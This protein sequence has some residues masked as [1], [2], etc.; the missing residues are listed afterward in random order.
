MALRV[1]GLWCFGFFC[2][3]F[4]WVC[5]SLCV[6]IDKFWFLIPF[7]AIGLP[8][9]L[10]LIHIGILASVLS[11]FRIS[12]PF[13]SLFYCAFLLSWCLAEWFRGCLIFGGFPWNFL[14]HFWGN[15]LF[16]MQSAALLGSY[17]L[18]AFTLC[19]LSIPYF[20]LGRDFSFKQRSLLTGSLALLVVCLSFWG[21][22]RI[23][24]PVT[25][26]AKPWLRIVQ[27]NISQIDKMNPD[28][29]PDILNTLKTLTQKP[30]AK[31]LTA[32]ISG[33][34]MVRMVSQLRV[35]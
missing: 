14:A 8:A 13:G 17:G 26:D 33:L 30:S 25:F 29:I 9:T 22:H 12:K 2:V 4:Y 5:L 6:E 24:R 19:F 27:P 7:C 3:S 20:W 32:A 23:Q 10:S 15:N 11:F 21:H 16:I 28:K 35:L 18:S 34:R 1:I 31:P